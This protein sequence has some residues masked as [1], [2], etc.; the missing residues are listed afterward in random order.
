MGTGTLCI[1]AYDQNYR[2]LIIVVGIIAIAAF[3]SKKV[4]LPT[5]KDYA[6]R[7]TKRKSDLGMMNFCISTVGFTALGIPLSHVSPLY[8]ADP[9]GAIVG[10]N[11]KTWKVPGA[12]NKSIGGT[13]AVILTASCNLVYLCYSNF[14][15]TFWRHIF[16]SKFF[17]QNTSSN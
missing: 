2:A 10:R 5:M 11:V 7:K 1:I 15:I 6:L 4:T 8:Y 3:A 12:G 17:I 9:M 14:W 16:N 13:L